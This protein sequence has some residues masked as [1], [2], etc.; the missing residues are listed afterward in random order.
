M[1]NQCNRSM[2]YYSN[3]HDTVLHDMTQFCMTLYNTWHLSYRTQLCITLYYTWHNFAWHS[4]IHDTILHDTLPY[5][6]QFCTTVYYRI[7][8]L[9][10]QSTI[11]GAILHDTLPYMTQV[12]MTISYATILHDTLTYIWHNFERDS[13]IYVTICIRFYLICHNSHTD[14][15]VCIVI[16]SSL[17][18]GK[19]KSCIA[20]SAWLWG[21]AMMSGGDKIAQKSPSKSLN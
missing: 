8:N 7:H 20:S 19:I 21:F 1:M 3:I 11:H 2:Y 4:T 10:Q 15:T 14:P 18:A 9:A 17:T 12:C 6:T 16:L 5:M 13:T